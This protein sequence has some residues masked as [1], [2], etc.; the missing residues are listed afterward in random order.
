VLIWKLILLDF[1]YRKKLVEG[2]PSKQEAMSSNP[3]LPKKK[4]RKH[5]LICRDK[6]ISDCLI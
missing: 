5:K 1:I 2:L 6:K 3:V 4:E